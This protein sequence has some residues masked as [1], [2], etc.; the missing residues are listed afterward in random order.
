MKVHTIIRHMVLASMVVLLVCC[1][2]EKGMAPQEPVAALPDVLS[3]LD[4]MPDCSLFRYAIKKT[5]LDTAITPART[6]TAFAIDNAT[7]T[8]AGLDRNGIDR[9]SVDSIQKLFGYHVVIGAF[10]DSVLRDVANFA[11][12]QTIR[13]DVSFTPGTG[14]R[15]LRQYLYIKLAGG[16]LNV[17][18]QISN[19]GE[20]AI[21]AGNG[22]VYKVNRLFNAPVK[23]LYAIIQSRPE[24]SSYFSALRIIDSLYNSQR[25]PTSA[26]T[27]FPKILDSPFLASAGFDFLVV[28]KL[29]T[30][31]QNQQALATVLAPVNAAFVKAGMNNENDIRSF[32]LKRPVTDIK[33][34][35]YIGLDSVLK[36]HILF[37]PVDQLYTIAFA[38]QFTQ[39]AFNNNVHNVSLY[40]RIA[41]ASYPL[42]TTNNTFL[43]FAVNGNVISIVPS[44]NRG[45][46]PAVILNTAKDI[47]ATNGIIH[48]VDQL[49]PPKP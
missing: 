45:M 12:A 39:P 38:D 23:S 1:N 11:G 15:T 7:L 3:R 22:W 32:C 42:V 5:G 4:S 37:N 16:T 8:A 49:M 43:Q 34:S 31:G 13:Q 21:Q 20:R 24:L 14:Y 33:S 44:G 36:N 46:T 6:Y 47:L 40:S 19:N 26:A 41:N 30:N 27:T 25:N 17:N 2:K 9:L 28:N 29:G 48:E 35:K 18:G 10:P